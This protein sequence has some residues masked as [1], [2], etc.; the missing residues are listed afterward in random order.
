MSKKDQKSIFPLALTAIILVLALGA[1]A[2][3]L[4]K[5]T[6]PPTIAIGPDTPTIGK[7]GK[8][9]IDV[10]DPGSGLKSVV[11]TASQDGQ[12]IPL[13]NKT[14]PSGSMSVNEV[15]EL[16]K[17][18]LKEG[19]F[20]IAVTAHDASL[21]PF[22]HGG[23]SSTEKTF[24]YDA[25]PPRIYIKSHTNNLNQGG[26]ALL[27]FTLTEAADKAGIRVGDHFFPAYR[28]PGS[29]DKP[30]YYCLFAHP[31]NVSKADFKPIVEAYDAAGNSAKR[32]FNYHTN[33]RQ[34]RHDKIRLSDSF[35]EKTLPEFEGLIP[36][37][38]SALDRYIYINNTMRKENRAKLVDFSRQTS[39]TMLW[40]GVFKRLP[41][42]ANRAR[43]ADSRDY[44]YKGKKVDFQTHLGLDLASI[45]NAPVPAANDGTVVYADFLGIYGNV[46]VV[47]HGLGLQ[48]LYAHLNSIGVQQG[49]TVYRG[50]IVGNTGT[51]GLAGGD[52][53]HYG[54][55]VGG[56]PTQPLEWWDPNWIRHNITS[57]LQ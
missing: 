39:P 23:A 55:T 26:A 40:D 6:T 21:Y 25:T 17:G 10:D 9:T 2:F 18:Q 27:V 41:N 7:G 43:F 32:S 35:M 19:S 30:L 34:F 44:M 49:D 47:D 14:F 56:V 22:G 52:H 50:D 54:V 5:D 36:N 4:L 24:A 57:K 29:D 15:I 53:L 1:G 42:A 37:E 20:T 38:G 51:T 8:L 16:A 48:T 31:W 33:A 28:Q 3:L 12:T 45:R 13:I 11:I 46:V